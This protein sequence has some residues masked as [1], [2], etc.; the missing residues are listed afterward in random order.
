MLIFYFFPIFNICY[1]NVFLFLIKF[2]V[3]FH[4]LKKKESITTINELN[5]LNHTFN[6][7]IDLLFAHSI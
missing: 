6:I 2:L 4:I 1:E 7:Q 5:K 3:K